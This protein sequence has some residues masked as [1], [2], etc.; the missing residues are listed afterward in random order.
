[1]GKN[2]AFQFYPGDW[3][4]EMVG[5]PL[6]IE[7]F[8]IR[9]LCK[10]WWS[11][12]KG[13]L[14]Q[15]LRDFARTLAEDPRK[16]QRMFE[17]LKVRDI[18]DVSS[19][20]GL[21]TIS[22][23]RMIRDDKLREI[24]KMAG[25]L[26]GNPILNKD[27]QKVNQEDK[28]TDKQKPT[29]SSSSSSSSSKIKNKAVTLIPTLEQ[30]KELAELTTIISKRFGD[31]FNP[32]QWIQRNIILNPLTHLHVLRAL[33]INEDIKDPWPYANR[34]ALIEDGNYNAAD[35]SK[36]QKIINQE[37]AITAKGFFKGKLP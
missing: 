22:N 8:W 21:W 29:P 9:L 18:A 6:E 26:G 20:N 17:E 25:S 37:F 1:M 2:P 27:K 7:G 3:E 10:L 15:S 23:R 28:Q 36:E 34:I 30:K 11:K 13:T 12:N 35:Y 16:V 5:V 32:W 31:K 24:R 19:D 4:R 14:T 33:A